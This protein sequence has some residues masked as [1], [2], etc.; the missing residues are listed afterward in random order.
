MSRSKRESDIIV[1]NLYQTALTN[2]INQGIIHQRLNYYGYDDDKIR[3]GQELYDITKEIYNE[4]QRKKKDKSIASAKLK[5]IR[6]RLQKFYAFDRQRA[7]FVFR[8]DRIIRKRLSINKPLPNKS[9]GWIMSI[10]IFYSLLNESKKI[11][12]KVSKIRISQ[13]RILEGLELTEKLLKAKA[14]HVLASAVSKSYNRKKDE[15][16]LILDDWMGGFFQLARIALK[17]QP[18]LLESIGIKVSSNPKKRGRKKKNAIKKKVKNP[19]NH[20][21]TPEPLKPFPPRQRISLCFGSRDPFN[22]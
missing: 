22:L 16:L 15:A 19:E 1:L 4:A 9:A 2:A 13:E 5:E 3:E 20:P 14:N 21:E 7:K 6:G 17:D 12:D 10:K 11:Q 18:Q 8:K